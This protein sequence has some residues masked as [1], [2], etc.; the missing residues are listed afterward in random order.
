NPTLLQQ[1]LTSNPTG[2]GQYLACAATA[3]QTY[4][5]Q[6]PAAL[7]Q[8]LQSAPTALSQYL[9]ANPGALLQFL[10]NNPAALEQF[11]ATDPALLQRILHTNP[12]ILEQ[13]LTT[14][15][16]T[17]AARVLS[18]S[19][20]SPFRLRV[21]LPGSGNQ[22]MGGPLATFNIGSGSLF[23]ESINSSQL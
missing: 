14:E 2:L 6:N 17:G 4:L 23:T 7:L 5:Q 10:Q 19:L 13:F 18:G 15:G 16:T 3:L 22:A 12:A 1:Y 9:T 21:T 20:L 11:L 8:F